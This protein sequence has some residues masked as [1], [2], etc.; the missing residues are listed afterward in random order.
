M[1]RVGGER[2]EL[3]GGV[4]R[5]GAWCARV[6]VMCIV[7]VTVRLYNGASKR[8]LSVAYLQSEILNNNTHYN[9]QKKGG[10]TVS[11]KHSAGDNNVE[12]R[13]L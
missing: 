2:R 12:L 1:E 6:C 10:C 4:R 7:C 11:R 13:V 3:Q 5:L 9:R 8:G